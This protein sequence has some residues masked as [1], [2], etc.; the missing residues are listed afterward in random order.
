MHLASW[1]EICF[2]RYFKLDF[3]QLSGEG[4]IYKLI[5]LFVCLFIFSP[6]CITYVVYKLTSSEKGQSI[7]WRRK[8][9]EMAYTVITLNLFIGH[10]LYFS[11]CVRFA[12]TLINGTTGIDNDTCQFWWLFGGKKRERRVNTVDGVAIDSLLSRYAFVLKAG[13]EK[14]RFRTFPWSTDIFLQI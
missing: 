4:F 5:C 12:V 13:G 9:A 14:G 7:E 1:P 2:S 6:Q 3:H 11:V 10:F 8:H